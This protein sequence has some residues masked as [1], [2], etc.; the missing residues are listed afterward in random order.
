MSQQSHHNVKVYYFNR[1]REVIITVDTEDG[2]E[3]RDC[4]LASRE[5]IDDDS[6][7]IILKSDYDLLVGKVDGLFDEIKHGDQ[8]HQDWLQK[9][10]KDYFK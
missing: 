5:P 10:L 1:C 4:F 3:T 9:K 7:K 2:G 6:K 8:D